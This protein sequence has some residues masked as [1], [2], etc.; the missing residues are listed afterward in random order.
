MNIDN[1]PHACISIHLS[2]HPYLPKILSPQSITISQ[3]CWPKLFFFFC[4]FLSVVDVLDVRA[5]DHFDVPVV[6]PHDQHGVD[7]ECHPQPV[8]QCHE[9]HLQVDVVAADEP[10]AKDGLE[11]DHKAHQDLP[12]QDQTSNRGPD[13]KAQEDCKEKGIFFFKAGQ[14]YKEMHV[15]NNITGPVIKSRQKRELDSFL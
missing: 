6:R 12:G 8:T 14:L 5:L 1:L 15:I 4:T 2:I 13:S 7:V 11:Q 3:P 10:E 9:H